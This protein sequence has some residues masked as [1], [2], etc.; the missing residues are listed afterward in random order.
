[1]KAL[2]VNADYEVELFHQKLAPPAINQSIEFLL[3]FL[4]SR[5]LLSGK[6]YSSEYMQHVEK[7]TGNAPQIVNKGPFENYWGSL[8]NIKV[9]KWWNSKL[10]STELIIQNEWCT[11]TLIIKNEDDLTKI[12]ANKDL[13]LKD[14][15]GMSGQKFKLLKCGTSLKERQEVVRQALK[16]YPI[17]IEPYFNR[18]FDFS[19]YLFPD[20]KLIAYQNE[21]DEKFQY[22]G[23][24]L[25][26][27]QSACL[28]DLSFYSLIT[29]DKWAY[30]RDQT[31][32]IIN[33]YSLYPNELGYS[34][35]SFI[36]EEN[37]ELNIRVMSEINYR[38]TMGR[39]TY[40]LSQRYAANKSWTALLM[41][42][43]SA[44]PLWKILAGIEGVMVL[45]P[46]DSRFEILF[47]CA[48][49]LAEGLQLI[50]KINRLLPDTKFTVKI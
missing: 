22:K 4:E 14:P 45:S 38:R 47:L 8:K 7:L 17:I 50:E 43:T 48:D 27:V 40:E 46:G 39:M 31:Q 23:T 12:N 37:G 11:D 44:N 18:R 26:C 33:F 19:Q 41:A 20:G 29:K 5:P 25:N 3:V 34:I 42:K 6:K 35:D 36:Y 21:V 32:Q 30:F 16:N 15:Y 2:K 24:V 9:E 1:M 28:E 13:L 49:S 10:T